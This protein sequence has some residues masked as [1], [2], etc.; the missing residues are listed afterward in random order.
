MTTDWIF[1]QSGEV[2]AFYKVEKSPD[3]TPFA[4]LHW[5]PIFKAKFVFLSE[6]C[7]PNNKKCTIFPDHF[8][9]FQINIS[10]NTPKEYKYVCWS[11]SNRSSQILQHFSLLLNC[12]SL[13]LKCYWHY[14][15]KQFNDDRFSYVLLIYT[16]KLFI[17]TQNRITI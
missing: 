5:V 13:L 2:P 8:P 1:L 6:L 4:I 10:K 11:E 15:L 17:H 14:Q 9:W 3:P 16:L 7:L 12:T